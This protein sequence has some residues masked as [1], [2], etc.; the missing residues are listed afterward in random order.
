MTPE[1]K[2][3]ARREFVRKAHPDVGGDAEVFRLGM[4]GFDEAAPEPEPEPTLAEKAEQTA[5]RLARD[6]RKVPG[7]VKR[8]YKEGRESDEDPQPS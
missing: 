7:L 8:A 1:E 5:K 4:K 2:R 3:Q 6:W